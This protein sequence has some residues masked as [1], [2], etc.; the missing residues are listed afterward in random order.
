MTTGED[1]T[2][3]ME[4]PLTVKYSYIA[5]TLNYGMLFA[6]GFIIFFAWVFIRRR[7]RRIEVLEEENYE[8]EDEISVLERARVAHA[9]KKEAAKASEKKVVKK[10]TAKAEAVKT[11]TSVTKKPTAKKTPTKKPATKNDSQA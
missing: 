4:I 7:D 2:K 8:L 3:T 6:I 10:S 5:K 11:P 1:V 9:L